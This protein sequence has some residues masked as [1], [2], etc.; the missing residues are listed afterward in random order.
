VEI[1]TCYK[2]KKETTENGSEFLP[3][4]PPRKKKE[5]EDKRLER[6]FEILTACSDQALNDDCQHFGNMISAKLRN[7][8]DMVQL[9]I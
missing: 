8:N 7:F 1:W 3:P 2:P 4:Q 5:T 6:M 9:A